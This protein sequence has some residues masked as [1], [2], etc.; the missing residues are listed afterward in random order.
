MAD[1]E[2][3]VVFYPS[4]KDDFPLLTNL[5]VGIIEEHETGRL[6]RLSGLL[7]CMEVQ[8]GN[9]VLNIT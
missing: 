3:V 6:G 9:L 2:L 8:G 7:G 5:S 4:G 1:L